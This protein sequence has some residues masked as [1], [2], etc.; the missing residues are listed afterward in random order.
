MIQKNN[1]LSDPRK[2]FTDYVDKFLEKNN[3]KIK[4]PKEYK[5]AVFSLMEI[6]KTKDFSQI[7][8]FEMIVLIRSIY[9]YESVISTNVSYN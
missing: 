2:Q 1:K 4:N 8:P 6:E 7:D 9:L 3:R 5:T